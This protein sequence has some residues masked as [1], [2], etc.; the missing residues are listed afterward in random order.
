VIGWLPGATYSQARV[1]LEPGDVF[2]RYTDGITEAL[3][4]REEEWGESGS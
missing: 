4:E 1:Q 3:N 2:I